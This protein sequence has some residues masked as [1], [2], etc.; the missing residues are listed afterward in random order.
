MPEYKFKCVNC[1]AIVMTSSE[2]YPDSKAGGLCPQ[3]GGNH[4][5]NRIYE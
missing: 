2:N 4:T 3:Q 1:G 5:W